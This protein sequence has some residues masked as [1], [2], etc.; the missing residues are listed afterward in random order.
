MKYLK[1]LRKIAEEDQDYGL[2]GFVHYGMAEAYYSLEL[3][4]AKF[5]K[6][7]R[8]AIENLHRSDETVLL[9]RAYNLIG[10][11]AM[12]NGCFDIAYHY[13]MTP[14]RIASS[15]ENS[16][17][18][19]IASFNIAQVFLLLNDL[20]KAKHYSMLSLRYE[21]DH[22][23]DVYYHRNLIIGNYAYSLINLLLGNIKTADRYAKKIDKHFDALEY[24]G[25]D[26]VEIPVH[27]LRVMLAL[28]H[29]E[30]KE[31]KAL[32]A[33][34]NKIF[35]RK[36]QLFDY[37][38]DLKI[39]CNFLLKHGLHDAVKDIIRLI[40]K[41]INRTEVNY[42]IRALDDIKIA[43]Y[44]AIGDTART[45]QYLQEQHAIA[46][47]Q[48]TEQNDLYLNSINLI[49]TMEM[50]RIEQQTVQ[51]ENAALQVKANTDAL[52]GIPN[53]YALNQ[54]FAE[55]YERACLNRT[56]LAL[57][58][59]DI[60]FFKEYNDTYGHPA[61]D[62][63]LEIISKTLLEMAKQKDI[64][65]ARYGGDEFV[66]LYE[67]KTDKMI[68][69]LAEELEKQISSYQ[70]EHKANTLSPYV[71]ISQGICNSVPTKSSSLWEYLSVA[72][73]ALYAVKKAH[74]QNRPHASISMHH[75]K[76]H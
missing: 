72:D 6:S 64:F 2:V 68:H 21:Q 4:Y 51:K 50:L 58:I 57:E 67:N 10:L 74:R 44:E 12:N 48:S 47:K 36:V 1:A 61:G 26:G 18:V 54:A 71:T 17:V 31:A 45:L 66:I 55:A 19:G 62:A 11:D 23:E 37:M 70:I 34:T 65:C 8:K 49:D 42:M 69:A 41:D 30:E 35:S 20:K 76:H 53:R 27:C 15:V 40:D 46:A 60:D 16:V 14:L 63:C 32:I 25:M 73:A 13:Y 5:R 56:N 33:G 24:K 29:N 9:A 3:D 28:E 7:L 39:Y 22:K 52:T 59:L 43:Y 38:E 75:L